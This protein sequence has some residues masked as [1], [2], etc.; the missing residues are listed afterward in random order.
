[1]FLRLSKSR[2][3]VLLM[4]GDGRVFITSVSYLKKLVDG[5]LN[6]DM[7]AC[8]Q[9]SQAA[10]HGIG[11]SEGPRPKASGGFEVFQ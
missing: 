10:D 1:M 7:L 4:P 9:L 8:Q 5:Q 2:K 3:A 11:K 6:G